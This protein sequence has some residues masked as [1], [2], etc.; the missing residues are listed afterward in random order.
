MSAKN[1][2]VPDGATDRSLDP[3]RDERDYPPGSTRR[4]VIAV[5][6]VLLIVAATAVLAVDGAVRQHRHAAVRPGPAPVR[7]VG[8]ASSG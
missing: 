7:T 8:H 5:V 1:P 2:P 6:I 3:A 4:M